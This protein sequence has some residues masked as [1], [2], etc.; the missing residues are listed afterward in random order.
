MENTLNL[1]GI[2]FFHFYIGGQFIGYP[3]VKIK[4]DDGQVD[5]S[6]AYGYSVEKIESEAPI[7][8]LTEENFRLF[9]AELFMLIEDWETR[10]VNYEMLDGTQWGMTL[11]YNDLDDEKNRTEDMTDLED[12][13]IISGSNAFPD[14]FDT[15]YALMAKYGIKNPKFK[16]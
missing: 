6:M 13:L 5:V 9:L 11:S 14:N 16:Y 4:E 8:E 12:T 2:R 7:A 10:Y 15:L 1:E 3:N